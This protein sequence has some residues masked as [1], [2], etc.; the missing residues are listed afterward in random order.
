MNFP[1]FFFPKEFTI[2][3]QESATFTFFLPQFDAACLLFSYLLFANFS[4]LAP[5]ELAALMATLPPSFFIRIK[6]SFE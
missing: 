4:K 2:F 6:T 3:A 5:L 1:L